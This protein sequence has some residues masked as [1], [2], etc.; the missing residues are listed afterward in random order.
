MNKA[1]GK[2]ARLAHHLDSR[3]PQNPALGELADCLIA[4]TAPA[5]AIDL[6]SRLAP[7][8]WQALAKLAEFKSLVGSGAPVLIPEKIFNHLSTEI[9]C[10][11]PGVDDMLDRVEKIIVEIQGEATELAIGMSKIAAGDVDPTRNYRSLVD[12]ARRTGLLAVQ[13]ITWALRDILD[14]ANT[15]PKPATVEPENIGGRDSP[16]HLADHVMVCP[17]VQK[18]KGSRDAILPF[19]KAIGVR[20]PLVSVPDLATVR[21]SL[22]TKFPYAD[23]TVARVLTDL[24]IKRFVQFSPILLVGPPGSGK[25]TFVRALSEQLKV[26]LMRVDGSNDMS[27]SFSGT[28]RRWNSSEPCRPFQ[29]VARFQQAN[30]MILIDE[31][32]KAGERQDY[33]RLWD[34]MLQFMETE[35]ASRFHDPCLQS[36]LDLRHVSIIA[37]ANELDRLPSPLLDRFRVIPFPEPEA[38]H[39]EALIP[40]ILRTIAA[41]QGLDPRFFEPVDQ[42]ELSVLARRWKGGSIRPLKRALEGILRVRDRQR[43]SYVQ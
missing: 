31:L 6:A 25:S 33:G 19:E 34:S 2:L 37:T 12:L 35:T 32:D 8:I 4:M 7:P 41:D 40:D 18:S 22:L 28:E 16:Q 42:V 43:A 21:Q 17:T 26:G 27:S 1:H 10:D 24:S 15:F 5:S 11:G 3:A 29:A 38:R 36:E 13:P 23:H 9:D 30:P 39:L 20:F 14:T